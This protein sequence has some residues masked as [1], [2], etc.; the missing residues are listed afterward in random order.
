MS[1]RNKILRLEYIILVIVTLILVGVTNIIS[2]RYI[3]S[4][5]V[6]NNPIT[7]QLAFEQGFGLSFIKDL[8]SN[9]LDVNDNYEI[10]LENKGISPSKF[11]GTKGEALG[12]EISKR[13]V[14]HDLMVLQCECEMIFE[15]DVAYLGKGFSYKKPLYSSF[16]ELIGTQGKWFPQDGYIDFEKMN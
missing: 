9:I 6:E 2:I 15:E 4:K 7:Y 1:E 3:D 10:Y 5:K 16:G 8:E 13:F 11:I 14:T 12:T